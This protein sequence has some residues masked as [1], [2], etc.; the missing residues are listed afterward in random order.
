MGASGGN[1]GNVSFLPPSGVG[2]STTD[3]AAV[4]GRAPAGGIA[5]NLTVI[6]TNPP[7]AGTSRL[8]AVQ[9]N[10]VVTQ[11]QCVI[12]GSATSCTSTATTKVKPGD[13][14]LI[15]QSSSGGAA[16]AEA[17]YGFTITN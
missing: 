9:V 5:G 15:I 8:F 16:S 4:E 6:V 13:P 2:Q 12:A 11:A 10:E 17:N 14:V 1:L 3:E 7:G